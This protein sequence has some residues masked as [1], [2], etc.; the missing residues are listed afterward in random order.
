MG[1]F[2]IHHIMC[3]LT[4]APT[5]EKHK[6][7]LS[8]GR[9]PCY[10]NPDCQKTVARSRL[11][12]Q[13]CNDSTKNADRASTAKLSAYSISMVAPHGVPQVTG[14]RGYPPCT[15]EH[16][17]QCPCSPSR[18]T[19]VSPVACHW[20]SLEKAQVPSFSVLPF[21]PTSIRSLILAYCYNMK[22][23]PDPP[24]NKI[25]FQGEPLQRN[26]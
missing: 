26:N 12:P 25:W 2:L 3:L 1:Y 18:C 16:A 20:L 14:S 6:L 10:A 9:E 5:A 13:E 22:L 15:L 11:V 17:R 23:T 7:K 4:T 21:H 8:E 24:S 19:A